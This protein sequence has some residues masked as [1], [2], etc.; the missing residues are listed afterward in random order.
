MEPTGAAWRS[1]YDHLGRHLTTRSPLGVLREFVRDYAGRV[2]EV[3]QGGHVVERID[4]DFLGRVLA[5]TYSNGSTY[6]FEYGAYRRIIRGILPDGGEVRIEHD[7]EN[8][9][10][11]VLNQKGECHEFGV[12]TRGRLTTERFFDGRAASL[13]YDEAGQLARHTTGRG[14]TEFAYDNEGRLVSRVFDA[15]LT[16]TFAYDGMDRLVASRAA[17]VD[18]EIRRDVAGRT[19]GEA[20]LVPEHTW[21]LE[22]E[23]DPMGHVTR[24]WADGLFDVSLLRDAEARVVRYAVR[25]AGDVEIERDALGRMIRACLPGGAVWCR[26][27]D[28]FDRIASQTVESPGG[29]KTVATSWS[30]D[31]VQ[32]P[33]RR[34]DAQ[35][36]PR[37]YE[38][39]VLQQLTTASGAASKEAYQYDATGNIVS[40]PGLL[41]RHHGAG[42]RLLARDG[43]RFKYDD[44][45]C[46]VAKEHD[47]GDRWT[48][49]WR[50]DGLLAR[51]GSPDG[52]VT[53]SFYDA[54]A[55]RMLRKI[56]RGGACVRATGYVWADDEL[57]AELE[58]GVGEAPHG[59]RTYLLHDHDG[60]VL[61]HHDREGQQSRW[62]FYLSEP[63]GIPLRF[64][65]G[66]GRVIEEVAATAFGETAVLVATTD[67]R[68][69]GQ[70][71]DSVA[72]LYYNRHRYYDPSIGRYLSPDPE[73]L[74]AG[75]NAYRYAHNL[76]TV[77]AD[78]DGLGCLVTITGDGTTASATSSTGGDWSPPTPGGS[79]AT[80]V[81]NT[82]AHQPTR[83]P[84]PPGCCA[85]AAAVDRYLQQAR[86][87]PGNEGKSDRA[88]LREIPDGGIVIQH[89]DNPSAGRPRTP[90]PNCRQMLLELGIH[91][92]QDPRIA[93]NPRTRSRAA[94]LDTAG[95][96]GRSLR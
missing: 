48:Y 29:M 94:P 38:Y 7:L 27:W 77:F 15:E 57:V 58:F 85:E 88:L 31:G 61:G 93:G 33:R 49:E 72:G 66:A 89:H 36:P 52:A 86:A 82:P 68:F 70:I 35:D 21:T 8:R 79:V 28:E 2:V 23:Y 50:A 53:E 44:D 43:T 73:G 75:L 76:P 81:A 67:V 96:S 51:V 42:D 32:L 12:S 84:W 22:R 39:D 11:R 4:Y 56:W 54:S 69:P 19:V 34:T 13:Q 6:R 80:A 60:V 59:V 1:T 87:Q 37:L 62:A 40:G 47:N 83:A 5:R 78:P 24:Y 41:T 46:V 65:D 17:G 55:R 45:G 92:E 74:W 95:R 9:V 91:P 25:G 14:T 30:Y 71:E 26:S 10:R 90:C 18:V 64:V 3:R 16:N 63:G 20:V